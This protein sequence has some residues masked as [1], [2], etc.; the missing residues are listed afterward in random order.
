MITITRRRARCLRGLLRRSVLGITHRGPVPTL[1]FRAT[2]AELRL[3]YRYHG[4]AVSHVEPGN[5]LPH[6]ALAL[7]LD[8]LADFEGKDGSPVV[9][10]AAAP[11]RTVVRW[12]DRGV[13]QAR[14]YTVH[15]LDSLAAFP[16]PPASWS[17]AP[18]ALLDALAEATATACD[19]TTR[20]ALNCL[21]LRGATGEVVATDG[22]QLLVRGGFRFP[23]PGDVLIKRAPLF[24]SRDLPRDR[25]LALGTTDTHVVFRVGPWTVCC[26]TQ[27][28]RFPA[29]GHLVPT[30]PAATRLRLDATDAA[31]LA[32]ALGRLPGADELNAPVTLDLNGRVVIRAQGADREPVT[33]LVLSRSR[34][35]GPPV[36][37]NTHREF[38]ARAVRLGF[39]EVEVADADA[40]VVCRAGLTTYAWQPLSPESALAPSDAVTRIE[41]P[42]PSPASS[43]SP[44]PRP[45]PAPGAHHPGDITV[46]ARNRIVGPA[47]P[48]G[49]TNGPAAEG[50]GGLTALIREA[51]ALGEALAAAR[52]RAGRLAVALRRQRKRDRLVTTTLASLRQLKLQEAA[53]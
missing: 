53:E 29:V 44:R 23:W 41:P 34:A 24:A 15:P 25:S 26:A 2:G 50:N 1:V 20:Y 6:E 27:E 52:T 48:E 19:D 31:F 8:A 42:V 43:P 37:L 18:A 13:S 9:L 49:A 38:L 36:R 33:E 46:S 32:D 5:Y 22:H 10:E 35:A 4:L 7:P 21:Q 14:E 45:T 30:A 12:E 17:E 28:A 16:E 39:T 47:P 40:P 51:E 11:D 3:E